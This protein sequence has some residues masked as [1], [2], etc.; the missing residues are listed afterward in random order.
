[1]PHPVPRVAFDQA[2][3]RAN[4]LQQLKNCRYTPHLQSIS[5]SVL[6]SNSRVL[7]EGIG[8]VDTL[9]VASNPVVDLV[10]QSELDVFDST[11]AE[12][13]FA[14]NPLQESE[15][16]CVCGLGHERRDKPP[17]VVRV[18]TGRWLC[19]SGEEFD[20]PHMSA[21]AGEDD[22]F[23]SPSNLL[24]SV[25]NEQSTALENFVPEF[26]ARERP[27][28]K[29]VFCTVWAVWFPQGG[30]PA[31]PLCGVHTVSCNGYITT[32]TTRQGF[33]AALCGSVGQ[34][35]ADIDDIL[36]LLSQ[37]ELLQMVVDRKTFPPKH[38]RKC[39]ASSAFL[40]QLEHTELFRLKKETVQ[41]SS[42]WD[43]PV[44]VISPS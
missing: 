17:Q 19:L 20:N 24:L 27:G 34:G 41:S 25:E 8:N 37:E 28:E 16:D 6:F 21:L 3:L 43:V 32:E 35:D 7:G 4:V 31:Q 1:M 39:L 44:G 40:R 15:V 36:Q 30:D 22:E 11:Q 5:V 2:T 10:L 9:G 26:L 18:S 14:G 42:L 38:V 33:A 12:V 29:I 23:I 13:C